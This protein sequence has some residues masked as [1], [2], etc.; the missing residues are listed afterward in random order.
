MV[1]QGKKCS[2]VAELLGDA[3][4]TVQYWGQRFEKEGF[5]GL[6]NAE[7]LGR[8]KRLNEEQMQEIGTVLRGSPKEEGLRGQI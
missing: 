1:A 4:R 5:A 3:Q 2:K 6:Y 7:K 8:P